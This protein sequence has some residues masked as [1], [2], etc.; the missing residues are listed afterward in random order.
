[1]TIDTTSEQ[2]K[3][4]NKASREM[5]HNE[6]LAKFYQQIWGKYNETHGN[7]EVERIKAKEVNKVMVGLGLSALALNSCASFGEVYAA[8]PEVF[9]NAYTPKETPAQLEAKVAGMKKQAEDLKEVNNSL[10]NLTKVA[11]GETTAEVGVP[12]VEINYDNVSLLVVGTVLL[13]GIMLGGIAIAAYLSLPTKNKPNKY[14]KKDTIE[15]S[16]AKSPKPDAQ[17]GFAQTDLREE[18]KYFSQELKNEDSPQKD[19][20]YLN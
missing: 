11:T 12:V 1:M 17:T 6:P 18:N 5:F 15:M 10:D 20:N 13:G 4:P 9:Q 19:K 14:E 16:S 3:Q 7:A 2:P 8:R